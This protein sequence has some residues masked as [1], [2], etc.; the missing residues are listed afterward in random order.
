MMAL[1]AVGQ[2][3]ESR[4]LLLKARRLDVDAST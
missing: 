1:I 4:P 2:L 3:E